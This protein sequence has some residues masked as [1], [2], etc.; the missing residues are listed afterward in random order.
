VALVIPGRGASERHR[1][2]DTDGLEKIFRGEPERAIPLLVDQNLA[3]TMVETPRVGD[4]LWAKA[5]LR[6][7]P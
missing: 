5:S 3:I 4:V 7:P 6:C 1:E 2:G